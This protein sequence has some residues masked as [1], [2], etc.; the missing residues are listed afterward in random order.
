MSPTLTERVVH[1]AMPAQDVQSFIIEAQSS[2]ESQQGVA[3]R[4]RNGPSDGERRHIGRDGAM[5]R[6]G[7]AW[8]EIE[9]GIQL[10]RQPCG[11]ACCWEGQQNKTEQSRVQKGGM[12]T[13]IAPC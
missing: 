13:Q 1:G 12:F 8:H 5:P 2:L 11:L 7:T 3:F 6:T 10:P 9:G 4:A